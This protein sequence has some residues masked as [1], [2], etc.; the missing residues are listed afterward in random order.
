MS[1]PHHEVGKD[2]NPNNGAQE[3]D[4]KESFGFLKKKIKVKHN[5]TYHHLSISVS[6]YL[7]AYIR[8]CEPQRDDYGQQEEVGGL[9]ARCVRPL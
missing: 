8:D 4:H 3:G 7:S 1:P 2:S 6:S 5:G 9:F